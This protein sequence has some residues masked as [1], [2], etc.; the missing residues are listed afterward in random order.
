MR[1]VAGR[2][3]A[4][5]WYRKLFGC[6]LVL[7]S[8]RSISTPFWCLDRQL[9]LNFT[10]TWEQAYSDQTSVYLTNILFL[11][12]AKSQGFS[13]QQNRNASSQTQS[14]TRLTVVVSCSRT[15]Y[16]VKCGQQ[17]HQRWTKSQSCKS[18]NISK[19]SNTNT[20]TKICLYNKTHRHYDSSSW[21]LIMKFP[22]VRELGKLIIISFS[23]LFYWGN[24]ETA[25]Q[26]K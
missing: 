24:S 13:L 21:D 23:Q 8:W 19:V 2:L 17:Y 18:T 12:V 25:K 22:K 26:D 4:Q 3:T 1:A 14:G 9:T 6:Q 16:C 7:V 11:T 10:G 15:N 5:R 20:H